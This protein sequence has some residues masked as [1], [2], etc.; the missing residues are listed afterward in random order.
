MRKKRNSL[1]YDYVIDLHGRTLD[2]ALFF[3]E[4]EI[5]SGKYRSIKIIHGQGEGILR[6]GIRKFLFESSYIKDAF[7]G[8]DLNLP[9]GSG[10]TVI[11]L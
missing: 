1:N 3:L 11:Y 8:E 6:N 5:F 7:Y 4:K 2:E 9:G 10:V